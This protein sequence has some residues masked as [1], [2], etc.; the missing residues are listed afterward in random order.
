MGQ[1]TSSSR[2]LLICVTGF[3]GTKA[4]A[5]LARSFSAALVASA[6]FSSSLSS[7]GRPSLR[8]RARR[9]S[10]AQGT[11]GQVWIRFRFR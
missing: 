4:A 5:A 3:T 10:S 7:S 2:S 1:R 6:A 8:R 11:P 9:S